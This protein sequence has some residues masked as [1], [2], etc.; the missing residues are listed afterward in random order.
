MKGITKGSLLL[1]LLLASFQ[2]HA[3]TSYTF[4]IDY[5]NSDIY[6][7]SL[8]GTLDQSLDTN[9][10][11]TWT[12]AATDTINLNL[13]FL[14][15]EMDIDMR[16]ADENGYFAGAFSTTDNEIISFGAIL[17]K[18]YFVN[19]YRFSENSTAPYITDA[20][21]EN[22]SLETAYD[23]DRLNDNNNVPLPATLWLFGLGLAGVVGFN[24]RNKKA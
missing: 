18:D 5:L 16:A 3:G 6:D 17:G 1:C 10:V 9:D 22:N 21:E 8:S 11:Y 15:S 2:L 13:Y 20:Y 4:E 14:D 19:I 7:I 24:W 12:A 23:L